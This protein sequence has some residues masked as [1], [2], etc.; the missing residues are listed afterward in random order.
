M[1]ETGRTCAPLIDHTLL[2]ADTR[3]DQIIQLCR[4]AHHYGFAA[5]CVVPSRVAL[6]V[7]SLAGSSVKTATVIGFP[8]GATTS[9]AKAFETTEAVKAGAQELDMVM[10][11][12]ALKDRDYDYVKTDI[13][14]V[15]HA[16]ERRTVKVI[17]ETTLLANDEKAAACN[18]A[19]E[20]GAHFVKTS[21][22]L[23]GDATE[24]DVRLLRQ[25]VGDRMGV[26]ASGGIR[27]CQDALTMIRAGA[28]R[29]GTSSGVAIVTE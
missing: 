20:S 26:K 27:T 13:L 4:E 23:T 25:Q 16:A 11:V 10:A 15:V 19:M 2:K 17:I 12:G 8:L 14:S 1:T 18:L 24:S 21:T 28:T 9:R 3:H 5:V 6:A 7:R 29:I 22:G